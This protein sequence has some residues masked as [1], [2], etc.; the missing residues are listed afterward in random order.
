MLLEVEVPNAE[1]IKES[2]KV[3]EELNVNSL[4]IMLIKKQWIFSFLSTG[5]VLIIGAGIF[6]YRKMRCSF[7]HRIYTY[8]VGRGWSIAHIAG[9]I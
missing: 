4:S 7:C 3:F 1:E 8:L 6:L 9:N 2:T 5:G